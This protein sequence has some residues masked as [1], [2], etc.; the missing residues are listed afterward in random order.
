[1]VEAH[2]NGTRD[3]SAPLWTLLM[4][5][6]FLRQGIEDRVMTGAVVPTVGS[7]MPEAVA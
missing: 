3:Y 6:A 1:L 4:F 2:Q 5:E 7:A